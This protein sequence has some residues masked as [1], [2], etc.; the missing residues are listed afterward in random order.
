M[1]M[2]TGLRPLSV[3]LSHASDDKPIVRQLAT[4]LR[5]A[6]VEVWLDEEKLLPGQDWK[7]EIA[8]AVRKSDAIIVCLSQKATTKEG[9]IQR[10]IR[11]ALDAADEKPDGTIFLI[12]VRFDDSSVPVRLSKW[13]WVDLFQTDTAGVKLLQALI[14]R[15]RSLDSIALPVLTSAAHVI[16]QSSSVAQ[17]QSKEGLD[18]GGTVILSSGKSRPFVQILGWSIVNVYFAR[19]LQDMLDAVGDNAGV[20]RSDRLS[21]IP[22]RDIQRIDFKQPTSDEQSRIKKSIPGRCFSS[23]CDVRKADIVR[24]NNKTEPDVFVYSTV[25]QVEGPE[26][27]KYSLNETDVQAVL[28]NGDP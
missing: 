12:P 5:S 17:R 19:N 27:E 23:Y 10:E 4:Y 8:E 7:A 18:G 14:H 9:Y 16:E 24:L 13:Q 25:G 26:G 2:L 11:L 1:T 20:S 6:G 3:F 28:A 21:R 22:A 15:A